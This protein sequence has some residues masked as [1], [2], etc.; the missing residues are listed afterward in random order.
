ME[1]MIKQLK[2]KGHIRALCLPCMSKMSWS[3]QLKMGL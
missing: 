2:E 1:N 3:L